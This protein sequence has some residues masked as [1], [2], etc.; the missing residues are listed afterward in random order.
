LQKAFYCYFCFFKKAFM[1]SLLVKYRKKLETT[2]TSFIRDFMDEIDWR[3]RFVGIKGTRGVG[4]TTL[5]LQYA[6]ALRQP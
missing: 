5:L 4:K 3:N 6:I 2:P 1:E